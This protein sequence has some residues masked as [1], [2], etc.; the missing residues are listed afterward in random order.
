MGSGFLLSR[1]HGVQG[2]IVQQGQP[3]LGRNPGE[4]ADRRLS[5]G[6]P[7]KGHEHP[8][9]LVQ[10]GG[11]LLAGRFQSGEFFVGCLWRAQGKPTFRRADG[12]PHLS[13]TIPEF[14][15]ANRYL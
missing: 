14:S 9:A 6:Q 12:T 1:P 11:L 3:P 10:D 8:R 4:L 13:R 2:R 5:F 15:G 7:A